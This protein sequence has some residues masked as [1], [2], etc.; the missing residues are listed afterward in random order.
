MQQKNTWANRSVKEAGSID[1]TPLTASIISYLEDFGLTEKEAKI[2]YILSRLGSACANEISSVTQYNRLQTYR[3]VKGLLDRGLVEISLERPRRYTP[4]KIEHAIS[5]LE[6]EATN[7]IMLLES[8]KPLLLQK[9]SEESDFPISKASYTFR[10]VQ[11]TKNVYKFALMLYES[12]Q[13]NIDIIFKGSQI[14]RW[15]L[16]GADDSL[17]KTHSKKIIARALSE[18]DENN[19]EAIQSVLEFCDLRHVSPLNIV[20]LV[21]IDGK[22]VL[23]CLNGNNQGEPENAIWT[24]HP[25]LVKMLSGFFNLLWVESKDGKAMAQH[26]QQIWSADNS[27]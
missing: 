9:W 6:Q 22:E 24:N 11:G 2:Y 19:K 13:K 23:I 12:A 3:S 5:L 20:P 1:R 4:L 25:D 18:F 10:I 26:V 16:E 21:L 27:A 7:R 14:T 17:Q 8:K 15:V